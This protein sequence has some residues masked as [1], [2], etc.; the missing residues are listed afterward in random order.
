M[1][2]LGAGWLSQHEREA[3]WTVG[4]SAKF[5]DNLVR[6]A[7]GHIAEILSAERDLHQASLEYWRCE[8]DDAPDAW[9]QLTPLIRLLSHV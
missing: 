3:I 1:R 5:V 8:G 6:W 9:F 2:K 7:H 4:E